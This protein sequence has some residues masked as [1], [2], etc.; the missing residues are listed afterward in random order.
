MKPT[1]TPRRTTL[2]NGSPSVKSPEKPGQSAASS[3]SKS[4]APVSKWT[5]CYEAILRGTEKPQP[6]SQKDPERF[7]FDLFCLAVDKA[8]LK[9]LIKAVPDAQLLE[10][11]TVKVR[12]LPRMELEALTDLLSRTTSGSFSSTPSKHS[13]HRRPKTLV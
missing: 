12:R 5:V 2:S 3:P 4:G 10:S 11:G 9:E 1:L 13:K 7:Y 6:Y 8:R